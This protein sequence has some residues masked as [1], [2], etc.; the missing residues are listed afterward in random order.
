MVFVCF[1]IGFDWL[2]YVGNWMIEWECIG[3][4]VY[5][6]KIIVGMKSIVVL[7]NCIF[8]GLLV[9]GYDLVIG[10]II[11]ECDFKLESINYLMIIMGGFEVMNEMICMVD[12]FEWN[13]VWFDFV[14]CY[15]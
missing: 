11:S 3:N 1:C 5:C 8:I 12:Y 4:M 6:D 13:E 14:V 10:I 9:L 7:F 15:K 2:V